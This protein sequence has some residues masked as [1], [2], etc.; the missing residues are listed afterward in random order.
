M[1]YLRER[2][3]ANG[4]VIYYHFFCTRSC[5]LGS[6][7]EDRIGPANKQVEEGGWAPCAASEPGEH[8][9]IHCAE[10]GGLMVSPY[11][12]APLLV[13]GISRP[14]IGANGEAEP[15]NFMENPLLD[16]AQGEHHAGSWS[17]EGGT[18]SEPIIY[19][20]DCWWDGRTDGPRAVVTYLLRANDAVIFSG[21]D[22]KPSPLLGPDSNASAG[23]LIGFLSC[24]PG[25]VEEDY[26]ADY[27]ERQLEFAR[28]H[29]D[30]LSLWAEE[31]E[32][33]DE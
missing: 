30:D 24:K 29:G 27:S 12:R 21:E 17:H 1:T 16:A 15:V 23:G 25:D 18:I 10:C 28:E 22:Y 19:R 6:F 33:P 9:E 13:G 4:D 26:F 2:H 20:L 5:W 31:L 7:D 11:R 14:P 32:T 8:E 3:A